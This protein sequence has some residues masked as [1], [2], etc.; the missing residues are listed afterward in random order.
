M[1]FWIVRLVL[2]IHRSV[3]KFQ[4]PVNYQAYPQKIRFHMNIFISFYQTQVAYKSHD[5]AQQIQQD[6]IQ[7]STNISRATSTKST[8]GCGIRH[9]DSICTE[10]MSPPATYCT[11]DVHTG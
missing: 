2:S 6:D 3:I 5:K 7:L 1:A 4:P 11:V 8:T 10:N 9:L